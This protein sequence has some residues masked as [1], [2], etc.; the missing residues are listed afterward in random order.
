MIVFYRLNKKSSF[1]FFLIFL[2]VLAFAKAQNTHTHQ[3]KT[4]VV[5]SLSNKDNQEKSLFEIHKK[6]I[7]LGVDVINYIDSL[8]INSSIEVEEI[9]S[10]YLKNREV[11]NLFFYNETKQEIQLYDLS[12]FTE[13]N[14]TPLQIIKGD[15]VLYKFKQA[16]LNKP[17][18]QKV[19]LYSPQPEV[20]EKV[21]VKPFN[22]ILSKPN[23]KNQQIGVTTKYNIE[24]NLGLVVVEEKEDYRFYYSNG[25]NYFISFFR[26]TES[27][28]G[29]TYGVDGLDV[30]SNK[31]ILVLVLEHT[32]TRN[33]L[34]YFNKNTTSNKNLLIE[35][36][37]K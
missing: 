24:Q 5:F 10:K 6:L 35:F 1:C 28:L 25:I 3:D 20:I 19:F 21:R 17:E 9:L 14:S 2:F 34:F 22:K 16:L 31:E 27:F 8:N 36:L 33:K 12:F 18:P 30:S 37:S 15:S 4:L 23:L 26:G 7:S 11:K 13:K 32:A 29:K